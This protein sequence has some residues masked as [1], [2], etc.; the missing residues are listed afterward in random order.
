MIRYRLLALVA[1]LAILGLAATAYAW[2][3]RALYVNALRFEKDG[4]IQF[5]MFNSG[6]GGPEFLC[7]PGAPRGQWFVIE[8]CDPPRNPYPPFHP[9]HRK[10]ASKA[11]PTCQAAVDRMAEMLLESK[12]SGV[13][14]H[15]QRD[16]C[17]VTETALKPL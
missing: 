2:N 16:V 6:L 8:S 11:S 12:L 3:L 5:T 10:H 7:E 1:V 9:L 15:V 17:L 14:V 4:T 13:P